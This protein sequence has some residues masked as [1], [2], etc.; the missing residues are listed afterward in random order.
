MTI[1]VPWGS[2]TKFVY[3][4]KDQAPSVGT[5]QGA[6][7]ETIYFVRTTKINVGEYTSIATIDKVVGGRENK[8]NYTLVNDTKDYEI[9]KA[10]AT[11]TL[12]SYSVTVVE[13]NKVI[14]TYEYLGDGAISLNIGDSDIASV[15]VR[16]KEITITGL[17]EGQTKLRLT[18]KGTN[19]TDVEKEV[20]IT[21]LPAN[22]TITNDEGTTNYEKLQDAIDAANSGDTIIVINDTEEPDGATIDKDITIDLGD[23]EIIIKEPIHVTPSGDVTIVADTNDSNET[24]TIKNPDGTAIDNEGNVVIG[25]ENGDRGPIIDGKDKAIDS[26]D[27]D[28]TLNDGKLIGDD[29]PPYAGEPDTLPG[30]YIVT[31]EEDGRYVSKLDNDTTPPVISLHEHKNIT[32]GP[33]DKVGLLINIFEEGSGLDVDQFTVGDLIYEVN[34]ERVYPTTEVVTFIDRVNKNTYR[35]YL[36]FGGITKSGQLTIRIDKDMVFDMANLGNAATILTE[37]EIVI[38]ITPPDLSNAELVLIKPSNGTT[39][40]GEYEAVISGVTDNNGIGGYQWE[41]RKEGETTWEV[42]KVDETDMFTSYISGA[43]DEEG[44]YYVRVKVSDV[45]GNSAYSNTVS[46]TYSKVPEFNAK[47]TIKFTKKAVKTGNAVS[48]VK[49]H[50]I[51]KSTTDIV[52]IKVNGVEISNLNAVLDNAVIEGKFQIRTEFD[53]EAYAN[54]VYKFEVKDS[55]GNIATAVCNVSEFNREAAKVNYEIIDASVYGS[56][57]IVFTSN[58]PVKIVTPLPNGFTI[59]SREAKKYSTTIVVEVTDTIT[60]IDHEFKFVNTVEVET[61]VHVNAGIETVAR[62]VRTIFNKSVTI[63]EV[64][65]SIGIN[66][67]INLVGKMK[68][69]KLLENDKVESYYGISATSINFKVTSENEIEAVRTLSGAG[70][71]QIVKSDGGIKELEKS[72][73]IITPAVTGIGASTNNNMTGVYFGT[74]LITSD[75]SESAT[76]DSFH[77]TIIN[78]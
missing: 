51:V 55:N 32:I 71:I 1:S 11:L 6:T 41:I 15:G 53:Y 2:V 26:E 57:K 10:T 48:L 69:A 49:I 17:K 78:K 28:F 42:I 38:D 43:V 33:A 5:A 3:N 31:E 76:G 14:V 34:G 16:G 67:A 18:A 74:N 63:S 62:N 39:S 8:D 4:G 77:V 23:N 66:K 13:G 59:D 21:V 65:G 61:K 37:G 56:A 60:E 30:K 46:F 54:T 36:E 58:E 25:D 50:T 19:Y 20:N 7:G 9:T 12:S 75:S 22:Y 24:G 27:G 47:P 73:E 64:Y 68:N 45:I 52:S 35:Y 29:N 70:N 44:V 72:V 40:D